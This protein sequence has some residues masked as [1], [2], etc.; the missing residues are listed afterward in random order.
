MKSFTHPE[1]NAM[2]CDDGVDS[3]DGG[4]N[5]HGLNMHGLNMHG[6]EYAWF[7]YAW[8]GICMV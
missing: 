4:L 1:K 5:M 8:F 2:R 3:V 7:E 6:L